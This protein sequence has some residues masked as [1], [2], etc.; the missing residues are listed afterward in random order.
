MSRRTYLRREARS[1]LGCRTPPVSS[2]PSRWPSG[3]SDHHRCTTKHNQEHQHARM[4]TR[5]WGGETEHTIGAPLTND[6]ERVLY[7]SMYISVRENKRGARIGFGFHGPNGVEQKIAACCI[8]PSQH[9]ATSH[10]I[11][12]WWMNLKTS[13]EGG[14]TP[15]GFS[16]GAARANALEGQGNPGHSSSRGDDGDATGRASAGAAAAAATAIPAAAGAA[17]SDC[18]DSGG[19]S[20]TAGSS[21]S[22]RSAPSSPTSEAPALPLFLTPTAVSSESPP[23]SSPARVPPSPA[24]PDASGQPAAN[25]EGRR[26]GGGAGVSSPS[27]RPRA[28]GFAADTDGGA[29]GG[30]GD[31]GVGVGGGGGST[32]SG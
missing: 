29:G 18:A 17:A 22:S 11:I 19:S 16:I 15:F 6:I 27:S 12:T 13:G 14:S 10:H 3:R 28:A 26:E 9:R 23:P 7:G 20:P 2:P 25:G 32:A 8:S 4:E 31:G 1:H 21:V 24:A 5:F 30:G